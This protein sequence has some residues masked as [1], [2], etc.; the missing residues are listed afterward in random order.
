MLK[1]M[2]F[3]QIFLN[4]FTVAL[5][6]A[7]QDDCASFIALLTMMIVLVAN[8]GKNSLIHV[9]EFCIEQICKK[10]KSLCFKKK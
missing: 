4:Y 3:M 1:L 10:K 7:L 9:G 5:N 6:S 2:N 8:V